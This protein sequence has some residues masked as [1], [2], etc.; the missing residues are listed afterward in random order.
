MGVVEPIGAEADQ[1]DGHRRLWSEG[2]MYLCWVQGGRSTAPLVFARGKKKTAQK[3]ERRRRAAAKVQNVT[4]GKMAENTESA[5]YF[6]CGHILRIC[7][8]KDRG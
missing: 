8:A 6:R 5:I 3:D 1:S 4:Q 7:A 2:G